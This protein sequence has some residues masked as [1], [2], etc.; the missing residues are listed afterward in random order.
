MEL[1]EGVDFLTSTFAPRASW[2]RRGCNR[3]WDNSHS[4]YS[5][6]RHGPCSPRREAR[7][8]PRHSRQSR[9]PT[10]LRAHH[11]NGDRASSSEAHMFGTAAY[12][13]PEQ[14]VGARIDASA[15]WYAFGTLLYRS[16]HGEASLLRLDHRGVD[17]QAKAQASTAASPRSPGG[18][19]PRRAL[20][21]ISWKRNPKRHPSGHSVLK[22]LGA[23]HDA[24]A[25]TTS[26]SS[27]FTQSTPFV[28]RERGAVAA[29][30][31]VRGV[32]F[33]HPLSRSS[34]ASRAW[35]RASWFGGTRKAEA[36]RSRDSGLG[37]QLLRARIGGL[38]G[39]RRYRRLAESLHAAPA[40]GRG[41]RVVAPGTRDCCRACSRSFNEWR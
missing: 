38:Q 25:G 4:G 17:G 5:V 18:G 26:S 2:T 6:P 16:A 7:Q 31:G 41:R 33:P 24:Q 36:V 8:H 13:A 1:I 40:Q 27:R 23:T 32:S 39:L 22:R 10:G 20:R 12:M 15:D 28:G 30:L 3:R 34:A 14:A 9:R 19:G 29:A 11:P 21:R 37:W 35:G